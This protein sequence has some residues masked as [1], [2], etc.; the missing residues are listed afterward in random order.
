MEEHHQPSYGDVKNEADRDIIME[1]EFKVTYEYGNAM[2]RRAFDIS[3]PQHKRRLEKRYKGF[4]LEMDVKKSYLRSVHIPTIY[5]ELK[6]IEHLQAPV[7]VNLFGNLL[8]DL[9]CQL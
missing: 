2:I 1:L 8:D 5:E 4:I 6:A 7:A 9:S 3:D